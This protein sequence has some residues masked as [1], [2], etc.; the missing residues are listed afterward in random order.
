MIYLIKTTKENIVFVQERISSKGWPVASY[1]TIYLVDVPDE[2]D[3]KSVYSCLT[4]VDKQPL[5]TIVV[6]I[7]DDEDYYYW[8]RA[9]E[10][11]WDWLK[12]HSR[13]PITTWKNTEE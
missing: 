2:E 13:K 9:E 6:K 7:S 5:A 4:T 12:E 11:I 10:Y 3:A 1:D 8:G